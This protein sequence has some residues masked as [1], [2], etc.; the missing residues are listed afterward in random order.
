MR[1][2]LAHL[3]RGAAGLMPDV[4]SAWMPVQVDAFG[5]DD[6]E[7]RAA[8]RHGLLDAQV[9]D[10]YVLFG[11]G[12]DHNNDARVIY[13]LD[14][15]H[16]G[17]RRREGGTPVHLDLR[18]LERTV[19]QALEQERLLVGQVLRERDAE[20]GALA[21]DSVHQ[22][23]QRAV[24]GGALALDQ[25][26]PQPVRIVDVRV[27]EAP[28]VA[29]PALVDLVVLVRGHAYELAAPLPERDAASDRALRADARRVRHVPRPRL[30]A[31]HAR[32]EGSDRAQVDDVAA[33]DRLQGLV[34]L[35]RDVRLHTA[36]VGGQLL[37]PRDLVVVARAPVAQHAALAVER[38]VRRQR[39]RLL[40][41]EARA[42]DAA[43]RVPVAEREVLQRALAALV[44]D[45]AVQRV[46]DEL[47]LQDLCTRLHCHRA[48]R[49][50]DHALGHRRRAPGLRSRR[51]GRDVDQAQAA[52][53]DR[54]ELVVVAEDRDLDADGLRRLD[55]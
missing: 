25:R 15:H 20:S 1:R 4:D 12:G 51:S 5:V 24:P 53:A 23:E 18:A 27:V 33:E 47:E 29:D 13:V 19:E 52:S 26:R 31:P 7:L 42:V 10:G 22:R 6:D 16:F 35:A 30:E 39:D 14:A 40:E 32:S 45:G 38:D 34:E 28:A 43:D 36:V 44:A 9:D 46:V 21:L 11:V 48:L 41:V 2:K 8:L 50:H 55:Y 54:V 3:G 49:L 37:L 17:R